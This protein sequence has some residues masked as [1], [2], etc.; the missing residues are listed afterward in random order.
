MKG[1]LLRSLIIA[2]LVG[3]AIDIAT[4]LATFSGGARYSPPISEDERH[5]MGSMT[6]NEV[7]AI[8]A[9]RE[10]KMT[11]WDWLRESVPYW[12]FW[13]E[14][15]RDALIPSFGIFVACVWV[16]SMERRQLPRTS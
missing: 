16:G 3:P 11:R 7:D 6:L 1:L 10:I 13:K 15:A 12:Y 4:T 14:V 9:K 2:I 5:R 8:L